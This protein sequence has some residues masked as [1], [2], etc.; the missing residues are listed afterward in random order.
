MRN[1]DFY[2]LANQHQTQKQHLPASSGT[3][4]NISANQ[5]QVALNPSHTSESSSCSTSSGLM[6][7]ATG[8]AGPAG[9]YQMEPINPSS[10]QHASGSGK[11]NG[12]T[13]K[14]GSISEQNREQ[15]REYKHVKATQNAD[16]KRQQELYEKS[17]ETRRA[18]EMR[19]REEHTRQSHRRKRKVADEGPTPKRKYTVFPGRNSFY[20]WGHLVMAQK[21]GTFY[22]TL[23]LVV[24]TSVTSFAFDARYLAEE[25][26]PAGWVIPIVG[27]ALFLCVLSNLCKTSF[28]DPG[29]IP[30]ATR[31]EAA[32][33]ERQIE[34]SENNG[35]NGTAY[36]PP[37]R[38]REITVRN[39]PVKLKYCFTCKIFRPPRASHCSI[40][41]NCVERFDHHCPWV[42]NCVGK[43]NY[44]YF[45]FFLV[46]LGIHCVFILSCAISHLVLLAKEDGDSRTSDGRGRE[47]NKNQSSNFIEAVKGSPASVIVC[48]ICFFSMWSIL[49]LAG[50][51]TYL[52]TANLTTNEDI[53]G[54]YS[55]KRQNPNYNP[56]SEG[57]AIANC[58]AVLC[59]PLNPSLIDARGYATDEYLARQLD[60]PSKIS[61]QP[62]VTGPGGYPVQQSASPRLAQIGGL[63]TRI[64][65][66]SGMS[67][68]SP[69]ASALTGSTYAYSNQRAD[70]SVNLL[71]QQQQQ[72]TTSDHRDD[73]VLQQPSTA[74]QVTNPEITKRHQATVEQ[75]VATL[76]TSV[77]R[78]ASAD[79][80][81]T[82]MI[83]SALD[84]DSLS[85]DEHHT[86]PSHHHSDHR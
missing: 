7:A 49:G 10:Y 31:A 6:G 18:Q 55:N 62:T 68:A 43:R 5:A 48:V 47:S 28:S 29:I 72:T 34:N 83:D 45:Y 9:T 38:T 22:L 12:R 60:G 11:Q 61:T 79:L 27:A 71:A 35:S 67:T 3:N 33:L 53:K 2:D 25:V 41:D 84:L 42:G 52:T 76:P 23:F 58:N 32:D 21:A 39:Q 30:R 36:R 26:E 64:A 75:S 50:F 65:G 37:P 24:G 80:N 78:T 44:R 81:T 19:Q 74:D 17:V 14:S 82:T 51:H 77:V 57:N 15:Y 40:C 63:E 46:S 56:F 4:W 59:S 66:S 69:N 13:A 54:S 86:A 8:Q 20:C 16:M 70:S 73:Q 85:G 1:N